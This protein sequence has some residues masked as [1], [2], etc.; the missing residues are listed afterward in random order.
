MTETPPAYDPAAA[1]AAIEA[2]AQRRAQAAAAEYDAAVTEIQ[3]RHN[4]QVLYVPQ[5][6]NDGRIVARPL[7]APQQ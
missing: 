1:R 6:T 4:V 7:I 3:E 2:D 5:F